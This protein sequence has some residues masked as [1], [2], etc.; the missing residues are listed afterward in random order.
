MTSRRSPA[1]P[2]TSR[3]GLGALLGS[4]KWPVAGAWLRPDE[5]G[6]SQAV[7]AQVVRWVRSPARGA[8][9]YGR[10]GGRWRAGALAQGRGGC[11]AASFFRVRGP[12]PQG[13]A[14]RPGRTMKSLKKESRH[15]IPTNRFVESSGSLKGWPWLPWELRKARQ[16]QGFWGVT[17]Q[18]P[19]D[20]GDSSLE[21]KITREWGTGQG[22]PHALDK[23]VTP[24]GAQYTGP[25]G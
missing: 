17:T 18:G 4:K 2:V 1:P 25:W 10:S 24:G 20:G 22:E 12:G 5:K 21:V 23:A 16:G 14:R 19:E 15:R 13:H 3:S 6:G 7:S 8:G 9:C 11:G